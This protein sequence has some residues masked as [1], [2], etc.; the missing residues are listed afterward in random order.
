MEP[1]GGSRGSPIA[2]WLVCTGKSHRSKWMMT[3]GTPISG[4]PHV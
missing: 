2:G 4:N 1:M 3:G